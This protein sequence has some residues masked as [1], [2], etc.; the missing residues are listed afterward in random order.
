MTVREIRKRL[1]LTQK[2]L[3]ELLGCTQGEVSHY[4]MGIRNP[5]VKVALA[6]VRMCGLKDEAALELVTNA[7]SGKP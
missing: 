2:A 4:E 5:P 1:G 6:L 7:V 3:A